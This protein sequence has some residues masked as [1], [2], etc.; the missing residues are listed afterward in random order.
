MLWLVALLALAMAVVFRTAAHADEAREGEGGQSPAYVLKAGYLYKFTPFVR[1]PAE[2]FES[3]HS[4]FRLCV[5]GHDPLGEILDETARGRRVNGHPMVVVRLPTLAKGA[6][7]HML[8]LGA[9]RSQTAQ[10]MLALTA[11]QPVLT[12]ADE[13][14][15][16]PDAVIQFVTIEGRVRFEIRA[17]AAQANGLALSS[18]LLALSASSRE[19]AK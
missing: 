18:K 11:G 3:A 4:P 13:A 19:P 12:V 10:E 15:E 14:L 2:A 16:A 6:G 17:D 7:C 1:W 9:S 5:A 8:F